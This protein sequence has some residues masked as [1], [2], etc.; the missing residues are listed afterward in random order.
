MNYQKVMLP[1]Y[2][3][4]SVSLELTFSIIKLDVCQTKAY[5]TDLS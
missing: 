3:G 1:L 2:F 5:I 4:E